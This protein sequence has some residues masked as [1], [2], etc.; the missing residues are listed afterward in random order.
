M[1]DRKLNA[2]DNLLGAVDEGLRTLFAMR[3][4][5]ARRSPGAAL[6]DD[7]DLSE[8]DQKA[9]GR[10]MRVNHA[11]EVAAQALYRG[12]L[13]TARDGS[14]R[15]RMR[16]SAREET[17]HLVWC[18][19][20]LAQLDTPRSLL[21]PLWYAGSFAIG[22]LAGLTG[23]RWSLGFVEETERQVVDHLDQHLQKLPAD[24]R[25]SAAILSQM[26]T[27][28]AGHGESARHAGALPLPVA[29]RRI[30]R[31]SSKIMIKT[32]YRL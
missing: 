9:A 16:Q 13:L 22:A 6:A 26:K 11:G 21:D 28:E 14:V 20:R 5:V 2:V 18:R 3:V 29:V 32:A 8:Q 24:D 19:E 25:A 23:D 27:E 17:D 12:Q 4:P 30:M 10:L 1:N 7:D 31:W 15:D